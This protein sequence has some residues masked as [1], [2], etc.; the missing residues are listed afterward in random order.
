MAT[1]VLMQGAFPGGG[2][3]KPGRAAHAPGPEAGAGSRPEPDIPRAGRP[4]SLAA[5]A[6]P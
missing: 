3:R 1:F 5:P 6:R 2:G 4:E